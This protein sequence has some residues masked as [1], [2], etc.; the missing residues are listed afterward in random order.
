LTFGTE[1]AASSSKTEALNLFSTDKA[2]ERLP[3]ISLMVILEFPSL[4]FG[5]RE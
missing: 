3:P 2:G 5:I 1:K 4:S